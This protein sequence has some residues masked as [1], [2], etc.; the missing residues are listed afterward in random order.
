[1]KNTLV[2]NIEKYLKCYLDEKDK[3]KIKCLD[4]KSEIFKKLTDIVFVSKINYEVD[5][6][7]DYYYVT[8]SNDI[9]I[10][11]NDKNTLS[12]S[13]L[14]LLED[15]DFVVSVL[16][17]NIDIPVQHYITR[18]YH[19]IRKLIK[20]IKN[21]DMKKRTIKFNIVGDYVYLNTDDFYYLL[22]NLKNQIDLELDLNL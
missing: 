7:L 8:T 2:Q 20:Q 12:F 5:G 18:A 9:I 17:E 6:L 15:F 14:M 21:E 10:F 22:D 11:R 4:S 16:K 19:K 3:Q 1:M 13:Y